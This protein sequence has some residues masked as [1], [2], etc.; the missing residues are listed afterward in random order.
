MNIQQGKEGLLRLHLEKI[1]ITNNNGKGKLFS[2]V[3]IFQYESQESNGKILKFFD[4]FFL[5]EVTVVVVVV[6][7]LAISL[8]VWFVRISKRRV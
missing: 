2:N 5:Q 4:A 3:S 6:V 7:C 1:I 8:K